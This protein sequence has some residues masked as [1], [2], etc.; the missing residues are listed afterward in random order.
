M[1]VWDKY[2]AVVSVAK[3]GLDKEEPLLNYDHFVEVIS[4]GFYGCNLIPPRPAISSQAT[5]I[6]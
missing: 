2:L 6:L 4:C 5:H 3:T 1:G